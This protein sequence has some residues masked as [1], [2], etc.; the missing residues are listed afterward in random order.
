MIEHDGELLRCPFC[1]G[2]AMTWR[3]LHSE[4][5]SLWQTDCRVCGCGTP[6]VH[7]PEE[8]EALWNARVGYSPFRALLDE[9]MGSA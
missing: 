2:K 6:P 8:A 1:N 7:T 5:T 9:R 4:A 3:P